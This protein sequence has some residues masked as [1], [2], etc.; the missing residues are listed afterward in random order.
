M[1]PARQSQQTLRPQ[2]P[3]ERRAIPPVSQWALHGFSFYTAHFVRRRFESLSLYDAA[4][5]FEH[6]EGPYVVYLNHPS[7][8][9]P[10][11]CLLLARRFTWACQNFAPID[12]ESLNHFKFFRKLG[13][14]G[15]EKGAVRGAIDFVRTSES[16]LAEPGRVLWVT[17]QGEFADSRL[18]PVTFKPGL[19]LLASRLQR[20]TL[21]P[22]ALDYSFGP[23]RLPR[24]SAQFG[25]PVSVGHFNDLDALEWDRLL[26][27]RLESTMDALAEV[28]IYGGLAP[29]ER[30]FS[31]QTGTG[32]IYGVWEN[33][34]SRFDQGQQGRAAA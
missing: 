6:R 9:D 14:F 25:E 12:Q 17:P 30:L 23:G 31:R 28:M 32:G 29:S 22:L 7:W 34:R 16:I 18:R 20:G 15:V 8:W 5:G 24:I 21:L 26:A 2:P 13:F 19:S 3:R 4:P 27:R 33:I 10:L 11:V 1:Q